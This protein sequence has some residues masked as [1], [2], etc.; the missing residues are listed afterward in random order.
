[1]INKL[2]KKFIKIAMISVLLVMVF[3]TAV[4]NIGNFLSVNADLKETLIMI[5]ENPEIFQRKNY[6]PF[7]MDYGPGE[8][9]PINPGHDFPQG[10]GSPEYYDGEYDED[11]WHAPINRRDREKNWDF[12]GKDGPFSQETPYSTRF[13]ILEFDSDGNLLS[14]NFDNIAAVSKD[15]TKEYLAVAVKN[16][17]GFG[18]Y[19][20]YKYYVYESGEDEYTGIFLS[21]YAESRSCKTVL[22]V[23]LAAA[24]ACVILVYILVV[25]LSKKAIDPVVKSA[26]R[27]KQFITDA[28]HE[29]KTPLTVI[30]TSLSVLEMEVGRQK[31]ID[32]AKGQTEK[33]N[34][35]VNDLV[36]LS[37]MDE[38]KPVMNVSDM[39]ASAAVAE[40]VESFRDSLEQ[41]GYSLKTDIEEG[42]VYRGD[43]Y[44]VRQ[45][46]SILLENAL[47]YCKEGGEISVS[48][49][50]GRKGIII[51]ESNPCE[52]LDKDELPKLFD[53]FYRADK[54]RT[55][56]GGFGV[57][58][59]IAR[60]IAE[61]HHGE[62]NASSPSENEILFTAELR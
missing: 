16:G 31:W 50:K 24:A 39:N 13:F 47:K 30:N 27:Q 45:L 5:S 10:D 7:P 32:K 25:L 3:L 35:L 55:S 36:T 46:V 41:K 61:A 4:L 2:R 33:M 28:S 54:A 11:D 6:G 9:E 59:S 18:Y 38:E 60:G 52:N 49:S 34:E 20:S 19:D 56:G 29:L 62:I 23:S 44:M 58:L 53:R 15:D 14:S 51:K 26:E 22:F 43:E 57:G 8:I 42:L 37:R 12:S 48:L 17:E 40:T 1:M 21:A